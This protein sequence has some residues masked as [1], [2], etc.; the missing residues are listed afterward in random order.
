M[1]F[2]PSTDDVSVVLSAGDVIGGGV[3]SERC[4]STD[5]RGREA[6]PDRGE[7]TPSDSFEPVDRTAERLCRS[8]GD[9]FGKT[10]GERG[11]GGGL[12]LIAIVSCNADSGDCVWGAG[13]PRPIPFALSATVAA[14]WSSERARAI[15]APG[16]E[17]T[18]SAAW[19][20]GDVLGSGFVDARG[21]GER[22]GGGTATTLFCDS[23]SGEGACTP[24]TTDDECETVAR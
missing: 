8:T 2:S 18:A 5:G 14:A 24:R 3:E 16:P 22:T 11:D 20:E 10:F 9:A 6:V 13:E 1:I 19:R 12:E 23:D 15:C 17:A 7:D 4:V 21:G